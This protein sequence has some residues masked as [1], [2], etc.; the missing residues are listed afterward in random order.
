MRTFADKGGEDSSDA[1]V[2]A[3]NLDFS[4]I[5]GVSARTK[6]VEQCGHFV[7]KWEG[8]NFRDLAPY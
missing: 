5:N 7:D 1:D 4:E 3:K 6:G 2:G 8:V